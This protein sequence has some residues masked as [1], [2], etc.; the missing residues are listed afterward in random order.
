M[1]MTTTTTLMMMVMVMMMVV[2]VEMV[3]ML[4]PLCSNVQC[5]DEVGVVLHLS[6]LGF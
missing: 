5:L 2:V 6:G 1:M 4:W 3:L